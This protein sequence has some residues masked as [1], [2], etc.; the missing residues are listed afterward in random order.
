M[1]DSDS[2]QPSNGPRQEGLDSGP[3]PEWVG[4]LPQVEDP[5]SPASPPRKERSGLLE[6]LVLVGVAL[7]LAL[8]LKT[9]VAEAYEIKGRSM[10]A[11]FYS[12]QRVVVLK[13]FY[14]IQRG[15][16]IVFASTED[17]SKDLIKRVVGL[18]GETL[19]VS[20]GS[21]Y[22]NGR[23]LNESYVKPDPRDYRD[24]R[25][26]ERIPPSHYYV[27]GD[28]RTDSHDSRFFESI[29]EENIRGKV[30]MRWWPFG[31]FRTF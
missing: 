20:G 1:L 4:G 22:V 8:T 19:V 11:T 29:P 25:R 7:A 3:P 31:E 27:L 14:H 5:A 15:D 26:E 17:P 23:K 2:E 13:A 21:V 6:A 12:G 30:V 28:N 18:P 10:E 24:L 9:Y 16:I